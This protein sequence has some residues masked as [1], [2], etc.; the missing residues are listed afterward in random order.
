VIAMKSDSG[1]AGDRSVAVHFKARF[2]LGLGLAQMF[3]VVFSIVLL[4]ETALNRW[5]AGAAAFQ[6][7]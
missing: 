6:R 7:C 5:S 1:H 4:L 3:M 2:R